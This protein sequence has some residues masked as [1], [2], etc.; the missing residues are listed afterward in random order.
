MMDTGTIKE[1][2]NPVCHVY[3]S[4][5]QVSA[6]RSSYTGNKKTA[7]SY[8]GEDDEHNT[9]SELNILTHSK[10]FLFSILEAFITHMNVTA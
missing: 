5:S 4:Q 8:T 10:Y 7:Q 2:L 3:T 9:A 1:G 6:N